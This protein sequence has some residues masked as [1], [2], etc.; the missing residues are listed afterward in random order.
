MAPG[1]EALQKMRNFYTEKGID[2]LK[3]AVSVPGVSLHYLLKGAV[4]RNAELYSPDKEAYD[5]LKEAVVG[6]PSLVFTRLHEVGV[7][8]IRSHQIAEPRL[9]KK[10]PRLRRQRP[11]SFNHAQRNALRKGKGRS[12][13]R[14]VPNRGGS[15][16]NAQTQR[17]KLVRVCRSRYRDSEALA[18]KVRG[19]VSLLLQQSGAG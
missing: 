2:I 1:L 8:E 19:N 7:T 13:R 14:R 16:T 15:F 4:E 10:H 3:D 12:L 9:C 6:G 17:R 11:L 5:M 18:P